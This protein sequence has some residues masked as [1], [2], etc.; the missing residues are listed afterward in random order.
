MRSKA[1]LKST[2]SI[3]Q[4]TSDWSNDVNKK[5][6]SLTRAKIVERPLEHPNWFVSRWS[7]KYKLKYLHEKDSAIL[8]KGDVIEIGLRSDSTW[9]GG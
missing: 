8:D 5:L 2:K 1:F 9:V 7:L 6:E 3:L 4:N